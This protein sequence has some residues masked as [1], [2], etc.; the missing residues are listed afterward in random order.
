VNPLVYVTRVKWYA[1]MKRACAALPRLQDLELL[2]C[3]P[4][5][6]SV[7]DVPLE[8]PEPALLT[9]LHFSMIERQTDWD[10]D[11]DNMREL[12]R[13]TNLRTFEVTL[14]HLPSACG[15]QFLGM[16]K[17]LPVHEIS[18]VQLLSIEGGRAG[19]EG[20]QIFAASLPQLTN[21]TRLRL[22]RTWCEEDCNPLR[23]WE[24]VD[25]RCQTA[26]L[27]Q[28]LCA[29]PGLAALDVA[30]SVLGDEGLH[31]LT[32]AFEQ[33]TR[34]TEISLAKNELSNTVAQLVLHIAKGLPALGRLDLGMNM[35]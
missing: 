19:T 33:L 31:T 25:T 28:M 3:D 1:E 24:L 18:E 22:P 15:A 16:W 5:E 13:F 27:A 7:T 14:D 29:L 34:L 12:A 10:E 9:R 35:F 4:L 11:A 30:E 20:V 32:P 6:M 8:L 23:P 21:L 26:L 2:H 17:A